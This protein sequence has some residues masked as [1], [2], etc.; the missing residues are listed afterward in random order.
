MSSPNNSELKDSFKR[1]GLWRFGWTYS[2]ALSVPVIVKAM[3][4]A[5]KAHRAR[6]PQAPRQ[7]DLIF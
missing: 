6:C 1:C 3:T 7:N 4:C 2:R 5:A